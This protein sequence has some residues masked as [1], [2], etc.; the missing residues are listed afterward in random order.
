MLLIKK[1]V[2]NNGSNEKIDNNRKK[3]NKVSV[4]IDDKSYFTDR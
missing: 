4:K 2:D 1:Y 3:T